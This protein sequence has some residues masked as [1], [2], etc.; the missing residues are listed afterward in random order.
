MNFLFFNLLNEG[1]PAFMYSTLL[2]LIICVVLVVKAFLKGNDNERLVSLI[3][4]VSLFALVWGF[5][6]QMVGIISAF[7]SVESFGNISPEVLAGGI[8][9]ALLNP[10][11]GIVVFLIARLGLIGLILKKK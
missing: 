9:V 4:H 8:K 3:K 6:G 5:L 10:V 7:D 2:L 11:F 1:G